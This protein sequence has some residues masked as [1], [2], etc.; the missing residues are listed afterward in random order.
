MLLALELELELV[1]ILDV[2]TR[3]RMDQTRHCVAICCGHSNLL[4]SSTVPPRT[5]RTIAVPTQTNGG[6]CGTSHERLLF[7]MTDSK[8]YDT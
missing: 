4:A 5:R 7:R 6:F 1:V 2:M 8:S 3:N